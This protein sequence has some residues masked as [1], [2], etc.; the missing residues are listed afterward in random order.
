MPKKTTP[1]TVGHRF[2]VSGPADFLVGTK[3][4]AKWL[5]GGSYRVTEENCVRVGELI[6]EG[7]AIDLGVG[8]IGGPAGV[9]TT[10]LRSPA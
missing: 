5:P 8:R 3:L 2:A 6:A 4:T 10:G 1:A 9:A 7:I